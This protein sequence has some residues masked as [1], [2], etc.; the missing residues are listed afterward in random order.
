MR[1][2]RLDDSAPMPCFCQLQ[3]A[4]IP[5]DLPQLSQLISHHDL[6]LMRRATS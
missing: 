6:S 1:S 2:M 3:C 5:E 4:V